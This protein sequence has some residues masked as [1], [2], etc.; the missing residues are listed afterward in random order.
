MCWRRMGAIVAAIGLAGTGWV[1]ADDG[2]TTKPASGG[3]ISTSPPPA[4]APA[5][6]RPMTTSAPTVDDLTDAVEIFRRADQA[7]GAVR[8][9]RYQ[10]VFRASGAAAARSPFILGSV[11]L[12]GKS[13][14]GLH[15][16]RIDCT[17]ELGRSQKKLTVEVG[18]DGKTYFIVDPAS[19]SIHVG[20]SASVL[21]TVGN[22]ALYAVLREF[23]REKPFADEI[24]AT[25]CELSGSAE[26]GGV[27]CYE[28]RVTYDDKGRQT[29]WF[30]G[31][32]DFLPRKVVRPM[33]SGEKSMGATELTLEKLEVEPKLD[34]DPFATPAREG[35]RRS[36]KPHGVK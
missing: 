16:A 10:A 18:T 25:K 26:V 3:A 1:R 4:S 27:A 13:F 29:T 5:A 35:F 14:T 17:M 2:V 6:S 15:Q 8:S 33:R 12:A 7:T 28:L 20:E 11:R 30:I 9:V 19:K 23:G 31:K 24:A 34:G 36:D 22:D 32:A 21:G